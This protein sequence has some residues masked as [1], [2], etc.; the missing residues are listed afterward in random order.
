MPILNLMLKSDKKMLIDRFKSLGGIPMDWNLK[1]MMCLIG[2][3]ALALFT[4]E[5]RADAYSEISYRDAKDTTTPSTAQPTSQCPEEPHFFIRADALYWTAHE[6]GLDYAIK[7]DNAINLDPAVAYQPDKNAHVKNAHFNWHAG[8]RAGF[9]YRFNH[10]NWVVSLLWT[11]FNTQT[12]SHANAG[13]GSLFVTR[14]H[15]GGRGNTTLQGEIQQGRTAEHA[16]ARWNLHYDI[17]D[18]ELARPAKVAKFVMLKP[19]FGVRT[20]RIT[21]DFDVRYK[22]VFEHDVFENATLVTTAI[23][24]RE[25]IVLDN[26][27]WGIGPRIGVDTKWM[28]NKRWSIYANASGSLLWSFFDV[29]FH[30]KRLNPDGSKLT[31]VDMDDEYH[32]VMT[33][34]EFALGL[35]WES[36]IYHDRYHLSFSLGWEQIL[37]FSLNQLDKFTDPINDGLIFKEHGNLNLSG[38]TLTARF[39][40]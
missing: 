30:E 17:L 28:F 37:W 36:G 9:G 24:P 35:K 25:K 18:L 12:T 7:N 16:R 40:F 38:V 19:L 29:D 14:M 8:A 4:A 10:D 5:V 27:F 26:D 21:Q 15:P 31:I 20:A 3:N 33:N 11:H 6:D 13:G 2:V 22:N 34:L 32:D 23:I 39:D 1:R